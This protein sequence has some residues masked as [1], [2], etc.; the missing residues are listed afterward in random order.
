MYRYIT[1]SADIYIYI[2][3]EMVQ[4]RFAKPGEVHLKGSNAHIAVGVNPQLH[5]GASNGDI[6]RI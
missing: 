6:L 1:I 2:Y 4:P 3:T 5:L